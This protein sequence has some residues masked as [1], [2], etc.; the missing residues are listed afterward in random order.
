MPDDNGILSIEVCYDGTWMTRGHS[1]LAGVGVVIEAHTGY[2][3]DGYTC[4]KYCHA[5]TY[6][7]QKVKKDSAIIRAKYLQ[8]KRKHVCQKNFSE[9]SGK[10]ES[11]RKSIPRR[12][13][14]KIVENGDYAPGGF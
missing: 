6:W 10:M 14:M 9:Y 8:W 7:N 12:K 11:A 5:C 1:S 4:C 3:V 2:I 13:R